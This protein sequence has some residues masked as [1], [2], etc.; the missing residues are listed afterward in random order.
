MSEN[1][2]LQT[3]STST[4][5]P[6]SEWVLTLFLSALPIVNIVLLCVW[7]F[8]SN[9]AESKKNWAKAT[10]IWLIIALAASFSFGGSISTFVSNITNSGAIHA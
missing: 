4:T 7:A 3:N 10:L 6:T 2:S 5:I 1:N 8:G 9:T